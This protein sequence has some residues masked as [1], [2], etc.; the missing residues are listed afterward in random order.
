MPNKVFLLAH[1]AGHSLSPTMHN[2]A[3]ERLGI[4]AHCEARDVP[5]DAVEQT[6]SSLRSADCYGANVT[7]PHK[8]A[9]IPFLDRL[10][11]AA[12]SI[13]AVNTIVNE[14]G[15]LLGHNTDASGFLQ[16]LR[17]GAGFELSGRTAVMLG[18]GGAARAVA[19]A[20]LK[21]GVTVCVYNRT[22]EKAQTLTEEFGTLGNIDVLE[23]GGLEPAVQAADLLVNTTSVGMVRGGVDPETSPLPAGVL[24]SN[25]FVYDLVYRPAKTKL[26]RDAEAAG[27]V[28]QNGLPMLVYQGA[29]AFERWTGQ[30]AP[31][32]TM[33]RALL[34]KLEAEA[35]E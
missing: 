34:E 1:P 29:E 3:F 27:L 7:V 6:V 24:P 28:I 18:A 22:F 8:L 14:N 32:E 26:L 19:Y 15:K 20:L 25:G 21:E 10:T 33:F 30:E 35:L 23:E 11:E 13:G 4:A 16:A 5:P 17:E 31:V 9:V 2:A 12:E